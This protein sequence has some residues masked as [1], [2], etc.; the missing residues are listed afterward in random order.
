MAPDGEHHNP[1]THLGQPAPTQVVVTG[2]QRVWL[3]GLHR[4]RRHDHEG[5]DFRHQRNRD[6]AG[7]KLPRARALGPVVVPAGGM[8]GGGRTATRTIHGA[9]KLALRTG[10]AARRVTPWGSLGPSGLCYAGTGRWE[11]NAPHAG[12]CRCGGGATQ[13]GAHTSQPPT[14]PCPRRSDKRHPHGNDGRNAPHDAAETPQRN[15]LVDLHTV[16]AHTQARRQGQA[17]RAPQPIAGRGGNGSSHRLDFTAGCSSSHG[18]GGATHMAPPPV[19]L[20]GPV[21]ATPTSPHGARKDNT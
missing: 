3:L 20:L 19:R 2:K 14:P 18:R 12:S 5:Q 8:G 1:P 21:A 6:Q 11:Q 10:R 7:R 17:S 9:H 4:K 15:Q 16:S 13:G